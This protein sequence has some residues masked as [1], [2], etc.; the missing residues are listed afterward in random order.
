MKKKALWKDIWKE[1]WNNKARF[2]ALFAII[3]LGV[4]FFGGIK[5]TGPNMLYTAN[6]Y[7]REHDLYD[8]KILS[9]MGIEDEDVTKMEEVAG[10]SVYPVRTLDLNVAGDEL[11]LR[12]FPYST[13]R[14]KVNDF[15]VI[16]GRLPERPGEIALDAQPGVARSF[17]LGESVRFQNPEKDKEAKEPSEESGTLD[18]EALLDAGIH[19]KEQE[20]TV[21][22]FVN[23]PLYIEQYSRGATTVGKG[24]LDGFGV[25]WQEDLEGN[26]YT[27][28]YVRFEDEDFTSYTDEYESHVTEK[29][30]EVEV[31]LNGRPLERINEIRTEGKKQLFEAER[32]LEKARQELARGEQ[33]LANA[34]A[35][36]DAGIA[37]YNQQKQQMEAQ[38]AAAE[39]ELTQQQAQL[40]Q[41]WQEYQS[42]LAIWEANTRQYAD[43]KAA[44]ENQKAS[45]LA[46]VGGEVSLE[47]L[48]ANPPPGEAGQQLGA[49]AQSILNGEQAVQAAEGHLASYL[50]ALQKREAELSAQQEKLVADKATSR[51]LTQQLEQQRQAL[52]AAQQQPTAAREQQLATVRAYLSEP[53]AGLS[54]ERK[55]EMRAALVR[56]GKQSDLYDLFLAYLQE[57]VPVSQVQQQAAAEE[58]ALAAIREEVAGLAAAVANLENQVAALQL[59]TRQQELLQQGIQ[60][61]TEKQTYQNQIAALERRSQELT[62]AR[63]VFLNEVRQSLQSVSSDI[64]AADQQ[65]ADQENQL[66]A[67]RTEL[68]RARGELLAGQAQLDEARNQLAAKR[69]EGEAALAQAWEQ[70]QTGETSYQEGLAAFEVQSRDAEV[71]LAE[72]EAEL[73]S[74]RTQL[75]KLEKPIYFV[76]DRSVN[77]GYL[78]YRDNANR[79]SAIATI[80]PVF[81][82]LIAAL[83]SFT[84]ITRMVEEQRMQMGTLKALGYGNWDIVKKYLVYA[85]LAGILGTVLGL[86][87]G[88]HLFPTIIY[89]AYSSLYNLP[90]VDIR[91]YASYSWIAFLVAILCTVGPA[92]IATMTA[93]R[94][95]PAALMR[96]KAPRKGKRVLLER[97]PFIWNRLGFNAKITVRNLVRYKIRNS[98]TVIGVA[99]CTILIL[100]GFAVKNSISGLAETQ[101]NDI[102]RY[103]AIISLN[104]D[105]APADQEMFDEKLAQYPEVTSDLYVL[106]DVFKAK[107]SGVNPQDVNL[108]VPETTEGLVEFVRLQDRHTRQPHVL[109]DEGA[110]ISEKLAI[111]LGIGAGDT[112]EL[113]DEE[114]AVYRIPVAAVTENYTGHYAYLTPELYEEIFSESYV[115]NSNLINYEEPE[116]WEDRFAGDIMEEPAVALVTFLGSI[117]RA[118]SDTLESLDIITLVLIVSAAGLAFVVLYNLTN[119]NVSERMRELSTIKVLGF[120]HLEVS[121]YIYRETLILTLIGILIGFPLGRLLCEVVLKMVEVDFMLF[122]ITILP[123]SYLYSA[124][125]SLAFSLVV[126]VIMHFKLKRVDMVEALKSVE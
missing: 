91:Y 82:F 29:T 13:E 124:L 17:E 73:N 77:P 49:Q 114:E 92:L 1:I 67:A 121:L 12:L 109:T 83:V 36:L 4:G 117:D 104:P 26:I 40:D 62:R 88:Y 23:S 35:E 45:L 19:L 101:F 30:E 125:L 51:T 18:E 31:A 6:R 110:I 5:A 28:A 10:V 61:E 39:Q 44:W 115:P 20:Y 34:R 112:L 48:A 54:E 27:E 25:V 57:D 16:E 43:A 86:L 87:F 120:Y 74:A 122:P 21:V 22:G 52:T 32:E 71:Q 105:A 85:L 113:R 33:E 103:D 63:N 99:G 8:L 90:D 46:Q 79:M 70:I 58:A 100:T 89:D 78:E 80:F 68:E 97:I 7:Y 116:E 95:D 42:G 118:F 2:L 111:L 119:I 94:E 56:Q 47:E 69:T 14:Q 65:F 72:G 53:L 106:Q 96:P 76:Q 38:L 123:M 41:G 66:V 64:A 108:F 102:M 15:L 84:T 55:Q 24:S 93:L 107:K 98:M 75:L 37:Q 3:L 126:M 60:L 50:T 59:D 81:F 9:T 11:L